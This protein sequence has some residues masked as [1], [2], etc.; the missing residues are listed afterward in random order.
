MESTWL[1]CLFALDFEA[2]LKREYDLIWCSSFL[3]LGDLVALAPHLANV[4]KVV[5]FHENQLAYPVRAEFSGERDH[6]YGFSQMVTALVADHCLF[7]SQW[8]LDSFLDEATRLLS[9]MPDAKPKNWMA[10]VKSRSSVLGLPLDLPRRPSK[11]TANFTD[12]QSPLI[13]WNHRWEHDKAPEDFFSVLYHLQASGVPFRLAVCGER[14]ARAPVVFEEARTRLAEHII[15][16][17]YQDSRADY[18]EILASADVV[19]STAKHEFF[20]ISMLEAVHFGAMPLVPNRLSYPELF[21]KAYRYEKLDELVDRLTR[22]CK[23]WHVSRPR[24]ED[25]HALAAPFGLEQLNRYRRYIEE[26]LAAPMP[27]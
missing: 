4:P 1:F 16:W 20:G 17:G 6:H 10:K 22:L 12:A 19:V 24:R 5:Y 2:T 9:R 14:Y 3:P 25:F 8:N 26:R 23:N 15:A 13:L 18:H 21:P 27:V 7:N 11:P